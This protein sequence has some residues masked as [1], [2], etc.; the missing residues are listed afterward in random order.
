MKLP[1]ILSLTLLLSGCSLLRGTPHQDT[2]YQIGNQQAQKTRVSAERSVSS[3]K[4]IVLDPQPGASR[5]QV[6]AAP[7]P[8]YPSDWQDL[9]IAGSVAVE[10]DIDETGA[11]G[12]VAIAGSPP[13]ELAAIS[14]H[15][16]LKWR[17]TPAA[18][19]GHPVRVRSRQV[20]NFV[21]E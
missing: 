17:F 19:D 20:F 6:L 11:V 10:F 12:N 15:A 9:G 3:A 13:P 18:R 14:V 8:E 2:Q 7:F 4:V 5:P 1:A 16:I 21:L